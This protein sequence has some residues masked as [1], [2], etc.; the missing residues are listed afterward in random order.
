MS[1]GTRRGPKHFL[2]PLNPKS[3]FVFKKGG[4][5]HPTNYAGFLETLD[6]EDEDEWGLAT[7][8]LRIEDRD[9]IWAYFVAP[10]EGAI[11]A[12][13]HIRGDPF[14][15]PEWEGHAVRIEWDQRLTKRLGR[16]PIK[17]SAFRQRISAGAIE[18]NDVTLAVLEG[19][20]AGKRPPPPPEDDDEVKF[21]TRRIKARRGQ[22]KFRNALMKAYGSKCVITGCSEPDALEAAHIRSVRRKG[23]H[24]VKNGLLLRA[25][26]HTLFDRGLI[27]IDN[28]YT[29][30]VHPSVKDE[31]YR[32]LDGTQLPDLETNPERPTKK[33]LRERRRA[34]GWS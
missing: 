29:V 28:D 15:K 34:K 1:T 25:D 19:W 22:P 13:G 14:W 24:S 7:N 4:K 20:L 6:A 9:F 2:Y 17:Y 23:R 8:F 21:T 16:D 3:D 27:D 33:R 30:R 32:S 26:I 12:V 10:P 31:S 11:R 5:E 18:A